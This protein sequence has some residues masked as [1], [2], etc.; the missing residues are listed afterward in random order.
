MCSYYFI[1][2]GISNLKY[3]VYSYLREASTNFFL[4]SNNTDHSLSRINLIS[5]EEELL[6]ICF[7]ITRQEC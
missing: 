2:D 3:F 5:Q 6:F 1:A 7:K 4:V